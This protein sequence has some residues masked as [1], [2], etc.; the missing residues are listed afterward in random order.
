MPT[1][2]SDKDE[3]TKVE[4]TTAPA[5]GEKETTVEKTEK[6]T[7]ETTGVDY[8]KELEEREIQLGQA[9]HTIVKE[10]TKTKEAK[11]E[12]EKVIATVPSIDEIRQAVREE[13]QTFH[14]QTR[15]SEI[16]NKIRSITGSEDEAKLALHHYQNTITVSGNDQED[17]ENAI[18]LANKK[19]YSSIASEA[20]ATAQSKD[21][22]QTTGGGAGQKV[23]K[24]V[25]ESNLSVEDKQ[26]MKHF[27]V[28]PELVTEDGQFDREAAKKSVRQAH[29]DSLKTL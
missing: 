22:V 5:S 21:T 10:K 7:E 28:S 16:E 15:K 26:I 6:T 29:A 20:Q 17:I 14:K 9:E 19:R 13:H 23:T 25:D 18:L 27:G 24:F 12:V 4:E 8:K 3:E 2:M 1:N 11:E